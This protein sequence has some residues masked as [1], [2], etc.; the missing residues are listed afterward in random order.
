MTVYE[1]MQL[2]TWRDLACALME[3]IQ[4]DLNLTTRQEAE[5]QDILD[6]H[7]RCL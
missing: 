5:Y 2:Q 6:R 3:F 4:Y 7:Q 1:E